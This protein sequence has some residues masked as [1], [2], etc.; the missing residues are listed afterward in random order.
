MKI[1]GPECDYRQVSET[2]RG[3]LVAADQSDLVAFS[4]LLLA[5]PRQRACPNGDCCTI[6]SAALLSDAER[7]GPGRRLGS[8]RK[9]DHPRGPR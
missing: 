9:V 2:G 8:P 5:C 4:R 1:G 3:L 6:L 7:D